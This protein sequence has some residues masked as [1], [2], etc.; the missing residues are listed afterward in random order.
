MLEPGPSPPFL[1]FRTLRPVR[2]RHIEAGSAPTFGSP[3][4]SSANR[5]C[6][7]PPR[8]H[9]LR[10]PEMWTLRGEQPVN[11]AVP[12]SANNRARTA[13]Q[14]TTGQH[15]ERQLAKRPWWSWGESNPRPLSGC[16]LRYDH[17]RF[18]LCGLR[19]AGSVARQGSVGSFSDVS[20]LSHRQR[21][22]PAV[23]P[24]FC[25]Q[26]AADGPRVPPWGSQLPHSPISRSGG[27]EHGFIIA[28][29][30][31]APFLESEQLRS[32]RTVPGLNVETDQPLVNVRY[33]PLYRI[34]A[35]S[36]RSARCAP[37]ARGNP[38]SVGIGPCDIGSVGPMCAP[39]RPVRGRAALSASRGRAPGWRG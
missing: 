36:V 31:G 15:G 2:A 26:A 1:T 20:G 38:E 11:R 4:A 6:V 30:C 14:A 29:S 3:A 16:R 13:R 24:C 35:T 8:H 28:V 32:R 21:S 5:G 25:C 34:P 17:S 39:V 27:E 23:L 7:T 37:S 10:H 22:F 18:S 19:T 33:T 9:E 12:E